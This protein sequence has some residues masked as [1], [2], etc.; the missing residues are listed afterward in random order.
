MIKP[1]Y[2]DDLATI[3]HGESIDILRSLPD[4]SVDVVMTD[5]PYSS[6]GQ[7]RGDRAGPSCRAKY[8]QT[9]SK[10][11]YPEFSGD[12]RDQRGFLIWC[13]LWIEELRRVVKPGGIIAC[14][15]DWRQ[16]PTMT[17]ALQAGGLVWRG[18]VPWT[19]PSAR[20]CKGRF[21]AQAEYLV[22]ATNGARPLDG[23]CLR[24]AFTFSPPP[25]KIR[26]HI[27][28]KPVDLMKELCAIAFAEDAVI[29]DPFMGA[30]STLV[31][32]QQLK[33]RAIGLELSDSYCEIAAE[34]LQEVG[35]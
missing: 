13:V 16:L 12:S 22:W 1:Y 8:Q 31:A 29:L 9:E 5:P 30:G 10:V 3:Y 18:I 24:G 19:K 27:T 28:E 17:D 21:S 23:P 26:K 6:G 25:T 7:M 34:R 15:S 14:F 4:N 20:P 32:A 33:R 2:Q 35:K 11:R